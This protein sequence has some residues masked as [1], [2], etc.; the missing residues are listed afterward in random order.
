MAAAKMRWLG[1]HGTRRGRYAPRL[2]PV[3][4]VAPCAV[5]VASVLAWVIY[6]GLRAVAAL[7]P[8]P[9]WGPA[10]RRCTTC[11]CRA[12]AQRYT[13]AADQLGH[14]KAA[15]RL[16]GVMPW[17]DL[18]TTGVSNARFALTSCVPT[19]ACLTNP[20]GSAKDIAKV[21]K[22]SGSRSS[23]SFVIISWARARLP[24][25]VVVTWTSRTLPSTAGLLRCEVHR[26]QDLLLLREIHQ[27]YDF[28]R[29]GGSR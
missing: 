3:C 16:A 24:H 4:I 5:A 10:F 23:A 27:R 19:F 22:K 7:R 11:G 9:K 26:R 2:W 29:G 14:E 28:V 15:V 8:T 25:G 13:T 12:T 6:R 20:T 18:P 17:P 21:N 1:R